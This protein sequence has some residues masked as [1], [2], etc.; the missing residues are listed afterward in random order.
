MTVLLSLILLAIAA[1]HILWAIGFWW[2]IGDEARLSATVVG[3]AG[4]TRMP[5][6]VPCALVAVALITAAWWPWY[7][8]NAIRTPGLILLALVFAGRG[9]VAY[10]RFWRRL[11]P[12]EPFATLDQR[13]YGPL[14]LLIAALFALTAWSPP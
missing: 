13:A 8:P 6:A 5:G 1:I 12:Q 14:C 2:P 10:T 3:A 9:A 11:T 7:A 4:I